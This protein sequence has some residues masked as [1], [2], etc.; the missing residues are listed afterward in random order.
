MVSFSFYFQNKMKRYRIVDEWG[1]PYHTWYNS[2]HLRDVA[3]CVF[4]LWDCGDCLWDSE[5]DSW[6]TDEEIVSKIYRDLKNWIRDFIFVVEE[7]DEPFRP[8]SG[9]IGVYGGDWNW[10][11][12]SKEDILRY[13]K[14]RR[15]LWPYDEDIMV[16]F[17]RSK[18]FDCKCLSE[19]LDEFSMLDYKNEL[20]DY[21][22]NI[23][24]YKTYNEL[25]EIIQEWFKEEKWIEYDWDGSCELASEFIDLKEIYDLDYN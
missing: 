21:L 2:I 19:I 22:N 6:L 16:E 1:E 5:K 7:G 23:I 24:W 15:D 10:H 17:V 13:A 3:E 8:E 9:E 14:G 12:F 11:N 4:C 20:F 25:V 18:W